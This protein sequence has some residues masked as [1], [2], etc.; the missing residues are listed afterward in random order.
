[1]MKDRRGRCHRDVKHGEVY[2]S[3]MY[4][5]SPQSKSPIMI[6]KKFLVGAQRKKLMLMRHGSCFLRDGKCDS[7]KVHWEVLEN[8]DQGR[9]ASF[10]VLNFFEK[11]YQRERASARASQIERVFGGEIC[12]IVMKIDQQKEKKMQNTFVSSLRD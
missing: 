5:S 2:Q 4:Y 9:K 6:K 8:E 3:A 7:K 12:V 1:M 11:K 10:G